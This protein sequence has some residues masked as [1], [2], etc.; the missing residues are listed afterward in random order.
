VK[1]G[2][3]G[4]RG[5]ATMMACPHSLQNFA[6]GGARGRRTGTRGQPTA[7]LQAKL[8]VA[9]VLVLALRTVAHASSFSSA[10]A[11]SNQN[12]MSIPRYMVVAMVRCS[13]ASCRRLPVR[14]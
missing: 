10:S 4:G 8:G 13:C 7:T 9:R 14:R 3:W 1:C 12:R 5:S 2:R 11:F 6:L